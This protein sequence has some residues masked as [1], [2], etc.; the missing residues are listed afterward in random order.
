M[1]EKR[2]QALEALSKFPTEADAEEEELIDVFLEIMKLEND[3]YVIAGVKGVSMITELL[4]G[5]M[6]IEEDTCKKILAI[7]LE[8]IRR[9]DEI[10]KRLDENSNADVSDLLTPIKIN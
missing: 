7:K 2:A 3:P 8:G 5:L 4:L 10:K 1:P 6:K 9:F